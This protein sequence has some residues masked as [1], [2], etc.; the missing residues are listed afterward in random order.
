MAHHMGNYSIISQIKVVCKVCECGQ[1]WTK[2]NH[3]TAVNFIYHLRA[4]HTVNSLTTADV[5]LAEMREEAEYM[6]AF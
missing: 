5:I 2:Q 3:V 6:N 1:R 4:D